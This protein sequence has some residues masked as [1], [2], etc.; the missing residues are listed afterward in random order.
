[1]MKIL[2][3]LCL[4]LGGMDALGEEMPKE[5]EATKKEKASNGMGSWRGCRNF[6]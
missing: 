2:A 4:V 6:T 5:N 1:M 3:V